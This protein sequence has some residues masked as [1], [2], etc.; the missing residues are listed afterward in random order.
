M[1]PKKTNASVVRLP[2]LLLGNGHTQWRLDVDLNDNLL[3]QIVGSTGDWE[4]KK[5]LTPAGVWI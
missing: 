1:A 3:F 5:A 4:T 2:A